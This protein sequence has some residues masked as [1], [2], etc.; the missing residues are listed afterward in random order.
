[1]RIKI[2]ILLMTILL[3]TLL[4]LLLFGSVFMFGLFTD[5][6]ILPKWLLSIV[7]SI[8]FLISFPFCRFKRKNMALLQNTIN[9][10]LTVIIALLLVLCVGAFFINGY[11]FCESPFATFDNTAGVASCFCIALPFLLFSKPESY[12]VKKILLPLTGAVLCLLRSKTGILCFLV[13]TAIYYLHCRK[14]WEKGDRVRYVVIITLASLCFIA[15]LYFSPDSTRGRFFILLNTIT[16][17]T[18][19]PFGLG[20]GGFRREYM[21]YQADFF[22]NNPD[23]S[24]SMLADNVRTPLNDYLL[25]FVDFGIVGLIAV[26]LLFALVIYLY[27]H[28]WSDKRMA[29]LSTLISIA[30]F[31]ALSYPFSYPFT[32]LML[33]ACILALC[34]HSDSVYVNKAIACLSRLM[35]KKLIVLPV[36]ILL[37]ALLGLVVRRGYYEQLL[38]VY[39]SDRAA[40]NDSQVKSL[41]SY[42]A[43]SPRFL[44]VR[45]LMCYESGQY[46]E[47]LSYLKQS[48]SHWADYDV[49]LYEGMSLMKLG[50]NKSAVEKFG[51]ALYMCPNRFYPLYYQMK[52]FL[53]VHDNAAAKK[54]AGKILRKPVKVYS[55]DVMM[56]RHEARIILGGAQ[57]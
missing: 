45:A 6:Y 2:N 12:T 17:L 54:I 41:D 42:F 22:R 28:S 19:Y 15:M 21:N 51:E 57:S 35:N 8:L 56:I 55:Q 39:D 34:V 47:A 33:V 50:K 9:N 46:E 40:L 10:A 1:M 27:R 25:C 30:V 36:T 7:F 20:I 32:W 52:I 14:D 18:G 11:H 29:Y 26:I 4:F 3:N 44:S 49:V 5:E 13:I 24:F 53:K 31:A 23:S 38:K 16:M 43:D 48:S 37:I